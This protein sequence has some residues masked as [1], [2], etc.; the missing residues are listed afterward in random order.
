MLMVALGLTGAAFLFIMIAWAAFVGK[1]NDE[2][3]PP[4]FVLLQLCL[5]PPHMSQ[6]DSKPTGDYACEQSFIFFLFM[7]VCRR[8]CVYVCVCVRSCC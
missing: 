7:C 5:L 2:V 1:V 4:S 8:K 3:K 6:S